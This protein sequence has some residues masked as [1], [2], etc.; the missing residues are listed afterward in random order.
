ML[1]LKIGQENHHFTSFVL[2]LMLAMS[3]SAQVNLN[4]VSCLLQN[5]DKTIAPMHHFPAADSMQF[6]KQN[7]KF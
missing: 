4:E 2:S 7:C 5:H 6:W 1:C 3:E